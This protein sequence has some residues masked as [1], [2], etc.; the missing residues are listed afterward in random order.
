MY[1]KIPF[2]LRC[3]SSKPSECM[4]VSLAGVSVSELWNLLLQPTFEYGQVTAK[5]HGHHL[6]TLG[7]F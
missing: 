6:W 3:E 5:A 7:C 4:K 1:I 2:S